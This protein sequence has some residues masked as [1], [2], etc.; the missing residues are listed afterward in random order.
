MRLT[1]LRRRTRPAPAEARNLLQSARPDTIRAFLVLL[2]LLEAKIERIGQLHLAD[3]EHQ[4]PHAHSVAN[5]H[6]N[7]FWDPGGERWLS[8]STKELL[9]RAHLWRRSRGPKDNYALELNEVECCICEKSVDKRRR[10]KRQWPPA[11][12][13]VISW[14]GASLSY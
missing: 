3:A 7:G 11:L 10:P 9:Q 4:P 2:H 14:L 5:A 6:F 8:A 13:P 12:D 1:R